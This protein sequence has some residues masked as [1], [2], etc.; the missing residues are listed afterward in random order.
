[1]GASQSTAGSPPSHDLLDRLSGNQTLP[2]QDVFWKQLL[3]MAFPMPLAAHNPEEVQ[4]KLAP[5]CQQLLVF[6]P[7]THNFQSLVLHS[8]VLLHDARG[9]K[10]Q[11][12]A[13][14]AL[15]L[16]GSVVK[17]ASET[18]NAASIIPALFEI[19]PSLPIPRELVTHEN[20]LIKVL[21][22]RVMATVMELPMSEANHVLLYEAVQLLLVSASSQ[23]FCPVVV[24]P[25]G[26]HPMLETMLMQHQ[27]APQLIQRLLQLLIRRPPPPSDGS[28]YQGRTS[29]GVTRLAKSAAS[30][31]LWLPTATYSSL[32][33]VAGAVVGAS[34]SAEPAFA[35]PPSPLAEASLLLILVLCYSSNPRLDVSE[36]EGVASATPAANPFQMA[37]HSLLDAGDVSSADVE[38]GGGGAPSAGSDQQRQSNTSDPVAA[39]KATHPSSPRAAPPPQAR[40][41]YGA[42]FIELALALASNTQA[43]NFVSTSA[44]ASGSSNSPAA[45]PAGSSPQLS[46]SSASASGTEATMGGV[47]AGVEAAALLAYS[48][49]H[50]CTSFREY[51][52]SRTDVEL[53]VVPLLRHMYGAAS[54]KQH[55][56]FMYMLQILLLLLSQD[57]SFASSIHL[58][59]LPGG[60]PWYKEQRLTVAKGNSGGAGVGYGGLSLGS[61]VVIVLLRTIASGLSGGRQAS[62]LAVPT[63]ALAALANLAPYMA[64]LHVHAAQRLV[65][66]LQALAKR[67]S[68]LQARLSVSSPAAQPPLPLAAAATAVASKGQ[69]SAQEGVGVQ[70]VGDAADVAHTEMELE[71]VSDCLRVLLEVMNAALISPVVSGGSASASAQQQQL[72]LR[73]PSSSGSVA[74]LAQQQLLR[75]LE[76][77]YALLHGQHVNG[78][79]CDSAGMSSARCPLCGDEDNID[80]VLLRVQELVVTSAHYWRADRLRPFPELRFVYEE[81]Q[82]AE[83]FFVPYIWGLVI[84]STKGLCWDKR[85]AELLQST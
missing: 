43:E 49:L 10:N 78:V 76:L 9:G 33:A 8:I 30:T 72:L 44:S 37:L 22:R 75:N 26:N 11:R 64:H 32:A 3:F 15:R 29:S 56:S 80:H 45:H 69:D 82:G 27:F 4:A 85:N 13:A 66:L 40:I 14:N 79:W 2:H 55:T 17:A 6:N 68:R 16:V 19:T 41:D 58:V 42:L 39:F 23:V 24:S 38:G 21:I 77:L 46:S 1:M 47:G 59:A 61:L 57:P 67:H 31:L 25:P 81:E 48:L 70:P 63:N 51:V 20:Q 65:S 36:G 28:L 73:S 83:S 35:R 84:M 7:L 12:P 5:H 52:L 71:V 50:G 34:A 60:A 54:N 53:L 62:D 74:L 18:G